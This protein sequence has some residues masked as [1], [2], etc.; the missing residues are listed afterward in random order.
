LQHPSTGKE[1]QMAYNKL[2]SNIYTSHALLAHLKRH[3]VFTSSGKRG[4]HG[5]LCPSPKSASATQYPSLCTDWWAIECD[6]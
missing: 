1:I 2:M 5:P 4:R 3:L 6:V